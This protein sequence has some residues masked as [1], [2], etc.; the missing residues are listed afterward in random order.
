MNLSLTE[1]QLTNLIKHSVNK[2]L[3]VDEQDASS[4]STAAQ[5]TAGTSAKQSGGQGYPVVGKWES[6]IERGADNQISVTKWSDVVGSKL[7]RGHANPLK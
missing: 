5:P 3:E 2:R 4:D 1:R 6:G 7:T